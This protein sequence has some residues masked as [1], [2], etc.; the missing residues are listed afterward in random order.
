MITNIIITYLLWFIEMTKI[1][2]I[3]FVYT[4]L[5]GGGEEP[6]ASMFGVLLWMYVYRHTVFVLA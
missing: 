2:V 3:L 1:T 6:L 5:G 4:F